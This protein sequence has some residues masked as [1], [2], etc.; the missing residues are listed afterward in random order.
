MHSSSDSL[1]FSASEFLSGYFLKFGKELLLI[2]KLDCLFEFSFRS[3]NLFLTAILDSLSVWLQYSVPLVLVAGELFSFCDTI[4]LR[5]FILF[6]EMCL[7]HHIWSSIHLFNLF[8]LTYSFTDWQFKAF[9]FVFPDG[10]TIVQVLGYSLP[11][12]VLL[13]QSWECIKKA[14]VEKLW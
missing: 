6:D 1:N 3:L 4:L 11:E 13:L 2:S 14:G 12:L 7:C 8:T 10:G 5:C 9:L